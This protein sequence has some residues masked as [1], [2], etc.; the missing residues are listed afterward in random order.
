MLKF[1]KIFKNTWVTIVLLLFK[2]I[3]FPVFITLILIST[4]IQVYKSIK[5]EFP[6][7]IDNKPFFIKLLFIPIN[8]VASIFSLLFI[9][10]FSEGIYFIVFTF[11]FIS[12]FFSRLFKYFFGFNLIKAFYTFTRFDTDFDEEIDYDFSILNKTEMIVIQHKF[13][14]MIGLYL[15]LLNIL[16]YFLIHV[17][18]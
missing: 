12:G 10:V 2:L 9:F 8:I 14:W 16:I 5:L 17:S 6:L 4:Y 18:I 13:S 15:P 1:L 11:A 3:L 7:S